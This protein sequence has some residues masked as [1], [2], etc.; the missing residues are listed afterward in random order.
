MAMWKLMLLIVAIGLFACGSETTTSG[1]IQR[2][3]SSGRFSVYCDTERHNLIY[4][5]SRSGIAV[6]KDGC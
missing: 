6:V 3:N 2:V 4:E 5:G 1:S